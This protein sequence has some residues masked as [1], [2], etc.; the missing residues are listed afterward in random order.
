VPVVASAVGG[1]PETV[2]D[3]VDGLLVPPSNPV[4]LASAVVRLAR[5]PL[6]R[7]RLGRAGRRR[8]EDHFGLDA[9]VSQIASIYERA[10]SL[11]PEL[12]TVAIR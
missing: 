10:L 4:A 1:I 5:D 9:S 2:R 6:V 8:V 12:A 11:V 7:A 3:G